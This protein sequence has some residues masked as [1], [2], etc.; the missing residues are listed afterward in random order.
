MA[1]ND[2]DGLTLRHGDFLQNGHESD[3]CNG[4]AFFAHITNITE[5]CYI[6]RLAANASVNLNGK[7]VECRLDDGSREFPVDTTT[8]R[9]TSGLFSSKSVFLQS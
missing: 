6:S 7:S 3:S 4:G 2:G 1:C 9:I 8:V 5:D